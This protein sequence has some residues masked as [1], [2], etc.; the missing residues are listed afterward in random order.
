MRVFD[1]GIKKEPKKEKINF[2]NPTKIMIIGLR[3]GINLY[4]LTQQEKY[5]FLELA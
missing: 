3:K 2:L 4:T 5:S 1:I